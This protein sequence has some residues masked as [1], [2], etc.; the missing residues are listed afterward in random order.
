MSWRNWKQ[1]AYLIVFKELRIINK[2][3]DCI[4]MIIS[5]RANWF[6][7][8]FLLPLALAFFNFHVSQLM[9]DIDLVEFRPIV[10]LHFVFAFRKP[11]QNCCSKNEMWHCL[12]RFWNHPH[13]T[14]R[15]SIWKYAIW[16]LMYKIKYAIT[17]ANIFSSYMEIFHIIKF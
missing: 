10:A 14:E 17:I 7:H 9:F 5:L 6:N 16:I 15:E 12:G 2:D 4:P 1:S 11:T 13:P 8:W 3:A